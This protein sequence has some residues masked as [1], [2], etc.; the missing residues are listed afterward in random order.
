VS[1]PRRTDHFTW[2]HELRRLRIYTICQHSVHPMCTHL[3]CT[4]CTSHIPFIFNGFCFPKKLV[5]AFFRH[6]RKIAKND[7]LLPHF[8]LSVRSSVH[9]S[10]RMEQ[11]S[12]HCTDFNK[13]WFLRISLKSVEKIQVSLKSNK[14]NMYF[15]WKSVFIYDNISLNSS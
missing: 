10:A 7:C 5:N 3:H 2:T 9:P 14:R 15:T 12:S 1:H 11:L 13:I 6:L 8:Y 4:Q